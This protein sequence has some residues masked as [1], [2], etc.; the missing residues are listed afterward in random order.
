[1][2]DKA[3]LFRPSFTYRLVTYGYYLTVLKVYLHDI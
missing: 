2:T 3:I 1:M